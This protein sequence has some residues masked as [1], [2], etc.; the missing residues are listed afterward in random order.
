MDEFPKMDFVLVWFMD[1]FVVEGRRS[2]CTSHT[3]LFASQ[4][5]ART[6]PG[7]TETE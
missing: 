1:V 5:V 7:K 4:G 6:T 2:P 3:D